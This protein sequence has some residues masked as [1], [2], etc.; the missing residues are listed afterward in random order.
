MASWYRPLEIMVD[1]ERTGK[2]RMV[3][4]N[5]SQTRFHGLCEH[6]HDSK[7][8]ASDCPV[9]KAYLERVFPPEPNKAEIVRV[10]VAEVIDAL[11]ERPSDEAIAKIREAAFRMVK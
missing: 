5:T 6:E 4:H 2:F 7:Q 10:F 3:E 9:A 8:E 11:P 1:G